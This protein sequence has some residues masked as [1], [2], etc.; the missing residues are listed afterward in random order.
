[1]LQLQC[2]KGKQ[3]KQYN[4]KWRQDKIH[5]LNSL[6]F[7]EECTAFFNMHMGHIAHGTNGL[8]SLPKDG[9]LYYTCISALQPKH[10]ESSDGNWTGDQGYVKIS[11]VQRTH[12]GYHQF[13]RLS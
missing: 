3:W 1:M 6:L 10:K 12:S 7:S 8:T 2:K 13:S 4:Y 11:T 9:A 5:I